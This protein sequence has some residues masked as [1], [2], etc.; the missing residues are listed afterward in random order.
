MADAPWRCSQCGTVNEPVANACRRC[1]RWPSLFD[2]EQGAVETD[3]EIVED[4]YAAETVAL[5]EFGEPVMEDHSGRSEL[6]PEVEPDL[7]P[8]P[9]AEAEQPPRHWSRR[10]G[11]LIVPLLVLLYVLIS[12]VAD[13]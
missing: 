13:R 10:V 5:P 4:P 1:G 7:G 2:L 8:E 9:E 11:S 3:E 6:E 12:I